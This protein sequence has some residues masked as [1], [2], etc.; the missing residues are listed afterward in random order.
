MPTKD[1]RK[2]PEWMTERERGPLLPDERRLPF[3]RDGHRILYSDAFRRLR[4]KAQVFFIPDNDHICTRMEHVLHVASAA[5]TVARNLG[6]DADLAYAIAIGHDLGHA[7]FG[8]HGEGVLTKIAS[9]NN[10]GFGRFE[11]EIHGLRQVDRLAR[12]DREPPGLNLTYA[13][14]D[15]IVSH[16]GE[17]DPSE[18][19]R[20]T[21]RE[22]KPDL[23][24]IASKKEAMNPTTVEG[25]IVKMV[26]KIVYAGRD[27]ED[28]LSAKLVNAQEVRAFLQ[29]SGLGEVNGKIVN[30][31]ISD[32]STSSTAEVIMLSKD[33][34][35]ALKRLI[36][37]NYENIYDHDRLKRYK[38]HIEQGMQ[39][40][41]EVLMAYCARNSTY[42]ASVF[43][44]F[45]DFREEIHKESGE[46]EGQ[47]VL[48]FIAGMTDNYFV[49][50][51]KEL[52][53][54]LPIA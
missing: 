47:V 24:M 26:D 39:K 25:C 28:A 16:C 6:L 29:D 22:D 35:K 42:E 21:P 34:G 11:H 2:C 27:V 10:I 13:V 3:E 4:H 12:L 53:L 17:D 8:H 15:G 36:K 41:F 20:P 31:L 48:D 49:R 33:K 37:W 43:K 46:S 30:T 45:K 7:P 52:F 9:K 19:L 44:V 38:P 18:A 54:P 5:A 32:L 14:R 40:L 51:V 1:V 23:S 50:A